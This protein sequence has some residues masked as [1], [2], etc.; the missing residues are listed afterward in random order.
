MKTVLIVDDETDFLIC[1]KNFLNVYAEQINVLVASNGQQAL[2]ILNT[3]RVDLLVTDIKMPVMDGVELLT[4][5]SRKHLDISVIVITAFATKQNLELLNK[6]G[7]FFYIVKPF[8]LET[9]GK[10]ILSLLKENSEAYLSRF[11][12]SNLLQL[13]EMEQKTCTLV[14]KSEGKIGYLYLKEGQLINAKM[15]GIDG[16]EAASEII[17]WQDAETE[18]QGICQKERKIHSPLMPILLEATR[19]KDEN[20]TIPYS[21]DLLQKAIQ[22]AEGRDF[23]KAKSILTRILKNQ[24]RNF[25]GWLWY[26]R[27]T[28]SIKSIELA[29]NNAV[30]IAPDDPEVA[31][32]IKNLKQ[33]HKNLAEGQ[34]CRCAFCWFPLQKG[35][36]QCPGCGI[37]LTISDRLLR[38]A[39]PK[40]S[41]ILK[42]AVD[43]YTR[44]IEREKN[45]EAHYY[46]SV[47][48]LNLENWEDAL[49]HLDKATKLS[50]MKQLFSGQLQILLNH[51]ASTNA[52]AA[53]TRLAREKQPDHPDQMNAPAESIIRKNKILV[54]EDSTTTRKVISITLSQNGYEII[55]AGDGLEALSKLNEAKPDLILLDIILPK[56]DGYKI[57]SII[58]ENSEFEEIPVIMLTSKDGILNKVKGKVA[59]SAAYLTK[60]FDP[61]QLVATIERHLN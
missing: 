22:L 57:L 19:L 41:N 33:A 45:P 20:R 60:P 51:M 11:T 37:Y 59:G 34:F 30:K 14:V 42:K 61:A 35:A 15:N 23:R 58:K 38:S 18:M 1:A 13:I 53:K 56:M 2:Q 5:L 31:V 48:H 7:Q 27:I 39:S 10:K 16:K 24:P 49:T 8:N 29:L 47:A 4:H 6:V 52:I 46:L 25:K 28:E 17:S 50:P 40:N 12:L 32:E 9:L 3:N 21:S 55:E 26:S 36:E 54:V 43:R 44:V